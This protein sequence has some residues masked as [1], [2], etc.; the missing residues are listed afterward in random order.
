MKREAGGRS[1][2]ELWLRQ[3]GRRET[4]PALWQVGERPCTGWK[5]KYVYFSPLALEPV[6]RT[7]QWAIT[8][9]ERKEERCL[10]RSWV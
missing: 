8:A 2:L 5:P 1:G 4:S 7:Q 10:E 3:M 6:W 9:L